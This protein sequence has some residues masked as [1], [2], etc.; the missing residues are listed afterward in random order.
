MYFHET[1]HLLVGNTRQQEQETAH[2]ITS[3]VRKQKAL[4]AGTQW[5]F[6]FYFVSKTSQ[7]IHIQ[8]GFPLQLNP[9]ENTLRHTQRCIF[10]VILSPEKLTIKINYIFLPLNHEEKYTMITRDIEVRTDKIK[11][12]QNYLNVF[13][14]SH[15]LLMYQ[16]IIKQL[17]LGILFIFR[18]LRF[19]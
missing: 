1:R 13:R 19:C 7:R 9:S 2:P 3:N 11:F 6:S 4:H 5:A 16:Q 8:K 17:C 10:M 14:S 18:H 15:I 12:I